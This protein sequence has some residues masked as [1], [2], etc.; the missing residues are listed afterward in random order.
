[1]APTEIDERG[2]TVAVALDTHSADFSLDL[3]ASAALDVRGAMW[4]TES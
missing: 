2:A 1:M 4:T 3:A